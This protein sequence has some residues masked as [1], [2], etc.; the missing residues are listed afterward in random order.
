MKTGADILLET[1]AY[2]WI[3]RIF[4][5]P[6]WAIM[7][8]YDKIEKFEQIEHILVRHEQ[9]AAF[10]AQWVSRS[11][12]KLWVAI[13][14]SWP[15]ATNLITGIMDA[16]MDS[17]PTLFITGQV[18]YPLMWNDV[19]QE[20][21][22]IWATM[23]CI[24]HSFI[25]DSVEKIPDIIN[26][27]IEISTSWRPWPVLVD[28]P[29]DIS[30]MEYTWETSKPSIDV[31]RN[32]TIDPAALLDN[33]IKDFFQL[34]YSAKKPILLIGQWVKFSQ[35]SKECQ[36]FVEATWIPCTTTLLAKGVI[37]E[38]Y[39]NYLWMLWMH[40]FYDAN[41]AMH[42][43]DLIINIGSRFDDRIVWNYNDFWANA[44]IIHVDIDSS[45]NSK[46]VK[47]DLFIHTDAKNFFNSILGYA[48]ESLDIA[49]WKEE[50][51]WFKKSH[52][53]IIST[54]HFSTKNAL[55]IINQHTKQNIA[56][57]VFSTDVWQHQM[58]ASQILQVASP[59]HW[60]SSW[61]AGTMGFALPA[62]IWAAF[63][64]PEK[65]I[66]VIAWDGWIQMNIQEL[67]VLKD[68]NLNIKVIIMNNRFLWMVRQWQELFFDKNYASTPIT[69]PNFVKLA[70]A[71]AIDWFETNTPEALTEIVQTHFSKKWPTLIEITGIADEDNIFPMVAPWKNLWDTMWEEQK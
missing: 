30:L 70:E 35:S 41:L 53:Y 11:S 68:H 8:L 4:G 65:T 32:L 67:Q 38:D 15:G 43:A 71:Y 58:W 10:A 47:T 60:L 55:N 3:D 24:K 13:A 33:V 34:L 59:Q 18:A 44:K 63:A 6:G 16:Y 36:D 20:V 69:S 51:A 22:I 39:S 7:P 29:K 52:P 9:G 17:I 40:W 64:N 48:L 21:D 37:H 12:N 66:V 42:N 61:W 1:L 57:Y 50:I 28:F 49:K 5:Y 27:A 46:V 23:S 31:Q 45:E 14:T 54:P 25:I 2:N 62:A 19:F 56:N 26:K